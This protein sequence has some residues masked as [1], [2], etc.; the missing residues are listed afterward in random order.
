[1]HFRPARPKHYLAVL[2]KS[3]LT[4]FSGS[5][6]PATPLTFKEKFSAGVLLINC[7]SFLF[8]LMSSA[9]LGFGSF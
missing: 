3:G 8:A 7:L 1:M 6:D 5:A 9:S 4:N 2:L